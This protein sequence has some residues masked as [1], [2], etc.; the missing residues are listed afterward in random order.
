MDE[1]SRK[2]D[3]ETFLD[4]VHLV[5]QMCA[6]FYAACIDLGASPAVALEA[7]KAYITGRTDSIL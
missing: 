2:Y 1:E 7:T 6:M 4:A 3:A 5:A